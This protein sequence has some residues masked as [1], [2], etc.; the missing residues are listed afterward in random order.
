MAPK[1]L[2]R[3]KRMQEALIKING[4]NKDLT[5]QQQIDLQEIKKGINQLVKEAKK[6]RSNPTEVPYQNDGG[7]MSLLTHPGTEMWQK[8]KAKSKPGT[9][10]WFKTWRTL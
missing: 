9:D 3:V 1:N 6:K 5:L 8:M 2:R 4:S 7:E 10:D